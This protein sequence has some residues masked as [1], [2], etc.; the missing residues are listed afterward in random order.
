M[1]SRGSSCR[2]G[3]RHR[4]ILGVNAAMAA[5]WRGGRWMNMATHVSS[6]R[7]HSNKR[8][9]NRMA[10]KPSS[11][12]RNLRLRLFCPR[13]M[14]KMTIV[15]VKPVSSALA[16]DE[17]LYSC[18]DCGAETSQRRHP[19]S[20]LIDLRKAIAITHC[21]LVV[22]RNPIRAGDGRA[23]GRCP[24]RR[25]LLFFEPRGP[26]TERP[27]AWAACLADTPIS[28]SS[29]GLGTQ[30]ANGGLRSTERALASS[31]C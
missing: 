14:S 21:C 10:S 23:V 12:P 2:P 31:R 3:N 22:S 25:G 5:L 8:W 4:Y 26:M 30:L 29:S 24:P 20:R 16:V 19:P 7:C 9:Y 18:M 11:C 28:I 15:A 1:T 13:C 17:L 6:N 27:R